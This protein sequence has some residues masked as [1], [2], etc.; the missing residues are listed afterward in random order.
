MPDIAM[1]NELGHFLTL[2]NTAETEDDPQ[3]RAGL[4]LL[5]GN[6]ADIIAEATKLLAVA[7]GDPTDNFALRHSVVLALAALRDGG[8]LELL[9]E[10]ALNPQP[11]PPV[12]AP[13]VRGIF[14]THPDHRID[15]EAL[16]QATIVALD[17]VDG[18]EALASD[19]HAGAL[20]TLVKVAAAP[21]NA[22]RAAALTALGARPDW[23]EHRD[24]AMAGLPDELRHLAHLERKAVAD[25]PQIRDPRV[26]LLGAGDATT[27]PPGLDGDSNMQRT[28]VAGA[29]RAGRR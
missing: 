7:P 4:E 6:S 14:E 24:A 29:P 25:V 12:E 21:S 2:L 9:A 27:R 13:S 1:S 18:I 17:A 22:I 16:V 3:Y 11:L 15:T 28:P 26:T 23:R 10:V 5:R 8:A 19:G 20:A